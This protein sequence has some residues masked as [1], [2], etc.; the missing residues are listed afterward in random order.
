MKK[1]SIYL[2]LF[3]A[4][5]ALGGC[6]KYLDINDNPNAA[7][8]PPIEGLLAN[9]TH[10]TPYNVYYVADLVS[11]YVQYLASPSPGGTADT[12]DQSDPTTSWGSIY[13]TLTDLHEMRNLAYTKGKLAYAGVADILTAYNLSLAS[14]IWGDLPYSEAFV[15]TENLFP[16]YDDQKVIY[17]S[18]LVMIDR[19]ISLLQN[20]DAEDQLDEVSDFIHHGSNAAWVKTAYSLKARL[21]NQ[22]S[23]TGQ[24]SASAVL[25]AVGNG[26]TSNDDDAAIIDF[27]V[28]NPWCQTARN[29][30]NLL[31]DGWLGAYFVNAMNGN[32]FGVFDPR[33]PYITD[34]TMFLDFRGTPNGEGYQ[35]TRNTDNA[36]STLVQ[37]DW[38]SATNSPLLI[39]TNAELRF[40][41]AEA[42]LRS[43]EPTRAYDAYLDGITANMTKLNLPADSIDRYLNDPAVGVGAGNITLELIMKEKYVACFLQPVTWVDMRRMDYN[44]QDFALPANVTLSTFIRRADYPSTE[45]TRN[46]NVPAYE[47]TDHL[48]WD[49]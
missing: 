4:L 42:E 1:Y 44:Y 34:T 18:C 7:N 14:N 25:T 48:W 47:R 37:G 36:Q 10:L 29:N 20:P 6:K 19:G 28:R 11:Y 15:G 22:V 32:T 26:Y 45:T 39:L 3:I 41:E 46:P 9:A 17:D 5:M 40:I 31:L 16:A 49:Q 13:N 2:S 24:Y 12:Y 43:G 30:D 27:S 35:G 38:Y 8:E 33:L 23:K 21:L